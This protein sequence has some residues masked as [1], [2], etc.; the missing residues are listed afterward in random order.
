[1]DCRGTLDYGVRKAGGES[2]VQT[3]EVS[4]TKED[5]RQDRKERQHESGDQ[6]QK[7]SADRPRDSEN[8]RLPQEQNLCFLSFLFSFINPYSEYMS[9]ET[10]GDPDSRSGCNEFGRDDIER[11]D[12]QVPDSSIRYK[13]AL[14]RAV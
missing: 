7:G 13:L 5:L 2:Q 3:H 11:E 12:P 8:R 14:T 10:K 4:E 1:M 9:M 6:E